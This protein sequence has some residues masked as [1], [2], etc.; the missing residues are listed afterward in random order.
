MIEALKSRA[1]I[2]R[3]IHELKPHDKNPRTHSKRQVEQ[4]AK[5]IKRFGFVNPVLL[6]RDGNILAGHG[7]IEA[8]KSLGLASVPTLGSGLID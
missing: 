4:I 7:R 5:S 1:V 3:P 8:A 2:E 6:D